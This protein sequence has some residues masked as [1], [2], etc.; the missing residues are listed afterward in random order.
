MGLSYSHSYAQ[1]SGFLP[2]PPWPPVLCLL[3]VC[4]LGCQ[5]PPCLTIAALPGSNVSTDAQPW[6]PCPLQGHLQLPQHQPVHL[7]GCQV[8]QHL[9]KAWLLERGQSMVGA[10]SDQHRWQQEPDP[11]SPGLRHWPGALAAAAPGVESGAA[12]E[13]GPALQQPHMWMPLRDKCSAYAPP[14]PCPIPLTPASGF[15]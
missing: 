2:Y 6:P 11:H 5:A 7:L 10:T 4:S 9:S 1:P 15:Q 8:G 3:V 12:R 13:P 14:M